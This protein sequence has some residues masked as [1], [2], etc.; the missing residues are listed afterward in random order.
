[1]DGHKEF[2]ALFLKYNFSN[3]DLLIIAFLGVLV[4]K[5]VWFARHNFFFRGACSSKI[6]KI[7]LG[8]LK[9]SDT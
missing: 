2:G 6:D 7:E 9:R 3:Y 1:M 4:T 8:F 5:G